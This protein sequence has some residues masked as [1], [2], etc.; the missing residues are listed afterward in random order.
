MRPARNPALP[1][2]QKLY[3]RP[4]RLPN[5]Q[6]HTGTA[7][8]GDVA[9]NCT[10]SGAARQ[11]RRPVTAGR[12]GAAGKSWKIWKTG[13]ADPAWFSYGIRDGLY[14]YRKTPTGST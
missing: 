11:R 8:S 9:A 7:E 13:A 4:M 3:L 1:C 5:V 12:R 6:G 14:L 10:P 2:A